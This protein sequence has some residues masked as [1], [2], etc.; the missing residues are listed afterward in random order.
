M[1]NGA[2]SKIVYH[3][4][5]IVSCLAIFRELWF[6]AK[7]ENNNNNSSNQH[8]LKTYIFY[9]FAASASREESSSIPECST[10]VYLPWHKP[11]LITHSDQQSKLTLCVG[12]KSLYV[13]N[14]VSKFFALHP[15][16]LILCKSAMKNIGFAA[17]LYLNKQTDKIN[18]WCPY[19]STYFRGFI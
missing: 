4:L 1:K 10:L 19:E 5:R 8:I 17:A 7:P 18:D 3:F 12:L 6:S 13:K 15:A 16:D 2:I 14:N 9:F 11:S